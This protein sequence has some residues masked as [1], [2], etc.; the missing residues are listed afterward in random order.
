M[1]P[2]NLCFKYF[3]SF[4]F[5]G[6]SFSWFCSFQ[7]I[8]DSLNF[9][10]ILSRSFQFQKCNLYSYFSNVDRMPKFEPG[11]EL[12][13]CRRDQCFANPINKSLK[14]SSLYGKPSAFKKLKNVCYCLVYLVRNILLYVR[15]G[16][17]MLNSKWIY[18]RLYFA[19]S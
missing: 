9:P 19:I 10:V 2:F 13:K 1:H 16:S 12:E 11:E 17:L 14:L 4:I 6:S 8:S 18:P 3:L 15:I 5:F 7:P